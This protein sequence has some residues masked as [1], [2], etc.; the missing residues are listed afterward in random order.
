MSDI[1]KILMDTTTKIMK[2][3]CTK[4]LVNDAERGIY[5]KQLWTELEEMGITTVGVPEEAGGTGF[6]YK[7]GLNILRT[8][9]A[10]AAPV[11]L[12]ET[13]IGN[14]FLNENGLQIVEGALSVVPTKHLE[15]INFKNSGEKWI[16]NGNASFVPFGR[17]ADHFVIVGKD[18]RNQSVL[19]VIDASQVSV[20]ES[21]NLAGEARDDITL[22]DVSVPINR[23]KII[24]HK[25]LKRLRDLF[26]LSRI[27]LMAGGLERV[28]NLTIQYANERVQFGRPIGKFQ[29]IKQQ[30]AVLTS[31]VVAASLAS[32]YAVDALDKNKEITHVVAMAKVRIGEA[33][34][35][36]TA[37][38]H[39]V[40]AA[41]GITHEHPLHLN[42]RRLWSWRDEGGSE[43]YWATYLGSYILREFNEPVWNY[44]TS[45]QEVAAEVVEK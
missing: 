18:D 26:A 23:S 22:K 5:P 21:I 38:A 12:A 13:Y 36:A 28:L 16:V 35:I 4:E 37:I 7:E 43:S 14:W 17:Y 2:E 41:I 10:Y 24:T 3:R 6:G 25:E 32:D 45:T 29:A 9:G 44:I 30:L 15:N 34:E 1:E 40:H 11:P 31:Q 42:T 8:A 20:S 19:T 27:V 33:V 39:Q